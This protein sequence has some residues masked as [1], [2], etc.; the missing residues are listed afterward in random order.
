MGANISRRVRWALAGSLT[1]WLGVAAGA[2]VC[3]QGCAR[4]AN[5]TAPAEGDA[6]WNDSGIKW[7]PYEAG[8]AEAQAT[9]KPIVLIFYTDWC[10]H[11]HNYSRLFH[12]PEVARLAASFVMIRVERDGHRDISA[13]YAL[14]GEYIPRTF[15]LSPQGVL[16]PGLDSGR[17]Q[18]RYYLDEHDASELTSRM[19]EAL[20]RAGG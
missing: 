6:D 15:F 11:C 16:I 10:P 4:G 8:L 17:E 1:L 12:D 9:A 3:L 19:E 18:Y 13:R 14:D 7:R 5:T 2:S 20:E